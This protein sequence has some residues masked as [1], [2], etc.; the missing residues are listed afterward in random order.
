MKK[1]KGSLI[2]PGFDDVQKCN[3]LPVPLHGQASLPTIKF[4][5]A[6]QYHRTVSKT[7]PQGARDTFGRHQTWS[8]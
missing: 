2:A 3:G 7:L 1:L 5:T 8:N 4:D 6:Y